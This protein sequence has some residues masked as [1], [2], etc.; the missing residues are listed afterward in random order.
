MRFMSS[1]KF[2]AITSSNVASAPCFLLTFYTSIKCM[3]DIFYLLFLFSLFYFSFFHF[4][5]QFEW[6]FFFLV[7]F[8]V[9][10]SFSYSVSILFFTKNVN[11]DFYLFKYSRHHWSTIW[12]PIESVIG[13]SFR[14]LLCVIYAGSH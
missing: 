12:S 8:Y 13:S 9:T 14:Y 4:M 5:I 3:L 2:S 7:I 10:N 11:H 1:E 6:L